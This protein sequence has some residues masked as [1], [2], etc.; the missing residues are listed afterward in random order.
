MVSFNNFTVRR[1]SKN[2]FEPISGSSG[3]SIMANNEDELMEA[4]SRAVA[5]AVSSALSSHRSVMPTA[6]SANS[7][8]DADQVSN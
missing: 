7:V 4:K 5:T 8:E 1:L 6:T 3:Q 2:Q